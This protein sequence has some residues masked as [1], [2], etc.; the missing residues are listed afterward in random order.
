MFAGDSDEAADLVGGEDDALSPVVLLDRPGQGSDISTDDAPTKRVVQ[1]GP[2]GRADVVQVFEEMPAAHFVRRSAFPV[3]WPT[4]VHLEPPQ[5]GQDVRLE[6]LAVANQSLGSDLARPQ[7]TLG[8]LPQGG[9]PPTPEGELAA[10][11]CGQHIDQ[12]GPHLPLSSPAKL[13]FQT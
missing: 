8:V 1:A 10:C 4:P 13:V 6:Q 7:P 5:S 3:L 11:L 9:R 2:E 12:L